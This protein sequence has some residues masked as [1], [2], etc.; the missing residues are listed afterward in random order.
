[1]TSLASTIYTIQP[2][3]APQQLFL[4]VQPYTAYHIDTIAMAQALNHSFSTATIVI[5]NLF[6]TKY[7]CLSQECLTEAHIF[8]YVATTLTDL[9][10]TVKYW[11]EKTAITPAA[12]A[13]LGFSYAGTSC[14]GAVKQL[15]LIAGRVIAHSSPSVS[16][17]VTITTSSTVE[18][19]YAKETTIHLVH[20]KKD[21]IV[22]HQHSINTANWLNDLNMD[23][24]ADILPDTSHAF[25]EQS[26]SIVLQRLSSYIPKRLWNEAM[27]AAINT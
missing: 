8:N 7:K 12:T 11:Q 16:P 19:I 3:D 5:I 20:G 13:L 17:S 18:R 10:D 1:M 27:Q 4:L 14:L 23:F 25:N 6:E 9:M 2:S 24:T 15:P 22:P 26:I 21:L